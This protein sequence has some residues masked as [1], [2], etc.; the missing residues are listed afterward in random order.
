MVGG[1]LDLVEGAGLRLVHSQERPVVGPRQILV[2]LTG[3]LRLVPRCVTNY[4]RG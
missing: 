3:L 2:E 4:D 1:R